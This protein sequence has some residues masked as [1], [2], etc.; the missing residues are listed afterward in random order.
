MKSLIAGLLTLA[1]LQAAPSA[2]SFTGTI[3]DSMCANDHASMRMGPTDGE[4]TKACID[5]HGATYVLVA[6][7]DVYALSDQRTPEKLAGQK[8]TVRGTLN[9]KTKTFQVDSIAAAK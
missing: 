8:V 7:K 4:C 9:A 1:A 5:E 3:S 2:R 6:G